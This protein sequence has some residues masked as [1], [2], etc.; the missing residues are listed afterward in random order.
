VRQRVPALAVAATYIGTVVGAGFASGQEVLQFFVA[1]G[2]AGLATLALATVLF[3]LYGL[4]I[5]DTG[6]R[7]GARSHLE[8]V[9][10]GGGRYLAVPIDATITFFLFGAL[11]TMAAG[12]GA[13]AA[14]QFGLSPVGGA[15][16]MAGA[17][18]LTVIGGFRR[19][20]TAVT[21]VVPLLLT[22]V[23]SLSLA[24]LLRAGGLSTGPA[25]VTPAVSPWPLSAVVYVSYNL[26]MS[27]AVLAPLGPEAAGRR[28]MVL[29]AVLGGAGLGG[30]ALA[31]YLA[32]AAHLPAAADLEV[33]M[34]FVA[35]QF[36][37]ALRLVYTAVLLA[38]VYTTS[39]ANLFGFAARVAGARPDWFRMV[40]VATAVV[41][42]VAAQVGFARLV[43]VVYPA[44]GYAGL[45][46]LATLTYR[47]VRRP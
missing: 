17:A 1:H 20:I 40:V 10:A 35:G 27:A 16:F 11:A 8:V 21:L 39:V 43:R 33:P 7:L 47:Y 9:R 46:F 23:V 32:L 6:R 3:S 4:A 13:I 26:V 24:S 18:A 19:V 36:G 22:G 12:A 37:P 28:A 25:V 31:V 45:L 34:V 15:A 29:G 2:V 30:G 42:F 14:E 38:E 5:L 41:A 44:V